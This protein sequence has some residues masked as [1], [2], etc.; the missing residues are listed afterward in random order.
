MNDKMKNK[1]KSEIERPKWLKVTLAC[2]SAWL[3]FFLSFFLYAFLILSLIDKVFKTDGLPGAQGVAVLVVIVGLSILS[4]VLAAKWQ[5]RVLARRRLRTNYIV[6]V[7]LIIISLIFVP[8][9]FTY[10]IM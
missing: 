10:I 7:I 4:A 6:L 1:S 8:T 3:T 2:L 9:P 5:H